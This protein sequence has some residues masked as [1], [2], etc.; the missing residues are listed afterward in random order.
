MANSIREAL[1]GMLPVP[2]HIYSGKV[3]SI[4]PLSVELQTDMSL[5]VGE[6]LLVVPEH[7]T[8]RKV[9]AVINDKSQT[10]TLKEGLKI[11]DDVIILSVQDSE[12]YFILGRF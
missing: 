10:I 5:T 9:S 6:A 8:D 1:I 3:K 11:G 12:L 4:K 7:L 2:N